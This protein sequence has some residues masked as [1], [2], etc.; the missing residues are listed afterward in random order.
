M[1]SEISPFVERA[2]EFEVRDAVVCV[3]FGNWSLHIPLRVFRIAHGRAA[4]A[5]RDHDASGE[6]VPLKRRH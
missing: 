6:V 1:L 3:D 2:P 5:L 4:K